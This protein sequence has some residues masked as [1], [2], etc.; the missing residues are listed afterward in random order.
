MAETEL[1]KIESTVA[2]DVETISI[3]VDDGTVRV[4]IKN[5]VGD[6]IGVF[7]FR[8]TDTG[9]V[10]RYNR[11][12]ND[13]RTIVEPLD[14]V[15]INPD[16]T[17]DTDDEEGQRIMAETEQRLYE[18]CDMLFDGNFSEAFFARMKPFS[19]INGRFYA[20][21]ALEAVGNLLSKRFDAEVR[22]INS[23]ISKYTHGYEA[24]SGKHKD[25]KKK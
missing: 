23:R 16:G 5:K 7:F 20:E 18:A 6:E 15:S 22:K 21:N 10:E 14:N 19:P 12:V 24:R 11:L 25:G 17:A 3:T 8:P 2:N 9:I 1:K 13:F 4:P